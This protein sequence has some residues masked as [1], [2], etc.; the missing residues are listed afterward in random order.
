MHADSS[1]H[2]FLGFCSF[3]VLPRCWGGLLAVVNMMAALEEFQVACARTATWHSWLAGST[4]IFGVR[5]PPLR[6]ACQP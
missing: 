3:Q 2:A 1:L 4:S 5:G 6:A